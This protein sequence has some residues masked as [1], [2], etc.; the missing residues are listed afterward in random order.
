LPCREKSGGFA[1]S[2]ESVHEPVTWV[3]SSFRAID[4]LSELSFI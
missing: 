1:T 2:I 4:R 3:H